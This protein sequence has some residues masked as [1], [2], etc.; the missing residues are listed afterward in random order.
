M[1]GAADA[2]DQIAKETEAK[3]I[4]EKNSIEPVSCLC[5]L[6]CAKQPATFW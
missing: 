6:L 2:Y 5:L 1:T 3:T 4:S